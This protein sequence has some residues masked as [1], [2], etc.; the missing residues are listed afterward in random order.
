M[1]TMKIY[2]KNHPSDAGHWIYNHGYYNAWKS[3]GYEAALYDKLSD[4]K[5]EGNYAV[6]CVDGDIRSQEDIGVINRAEKA[7][8]YAQPTRYPGKWGKHPNFVTFYGSADRAYLMRTC[9]KLKL[10]TFLS[11]QVDN[12]F[13]EWGRTVYSLPLAFDDSGYMPL[14]DTSPAAAK[15]YSYDVAYIGGRANNGFDEKIRVMES[16]FDAFRKEG[17]TNLGFFINANLSKRDEANILYHSK[18]ALNVHD[19][20]QREFGYDTNERTFKALGLSGILYSDDITQ[21]AT[22][23]DHGINRSVYLDSDPVSLAKEAHHWLKNT[24]ETSVAAMKHSMRTYILNNH[25]YVNRVNSLLRM[26]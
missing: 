1:N 16:T 18:I 7:W 21:I 20:F 17:I 11:G 26:V 19:V 15:K 25:T 8:M 6:M 5:D 24:S 10:W 3:A 9:E 12:L 4:I 13:S 14:V 22:M 23:F 2:L